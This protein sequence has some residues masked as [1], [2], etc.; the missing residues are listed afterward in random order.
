MFRFLAKTFAS[1]LLGLAGMALLT[2]LSLLVASSFIATWPLL[3]LSPNDRRLRAG[4]NLASA[5]MS[6]LMIAPQLRKPP[7]EN[8]PVQQ[9]MHTGH[10]PRT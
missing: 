2:A 8:R 10:V 6:L 1:I 7:V 9:H 5:V 3:R 4:M